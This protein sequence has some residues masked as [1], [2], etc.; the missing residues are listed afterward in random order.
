LFADATKHVT[1]SVC[2]RLYKGTAI[3]VTAEA[4]HSLYSEDLA[5]FG[6][7]ATFDQADSR[8]FVKLYGLPGSVAAQVQGTDA[9]KNSKANKG[10]NQ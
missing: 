3:A 2:V 9:Y 6:D 8:G 5:T 4:P 7:S 1:G 10:A